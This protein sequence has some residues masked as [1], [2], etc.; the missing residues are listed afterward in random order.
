MFK[1]AVASDKAQPETK[2]TLETYLPRVVPDWKVEKAR[3]EQ[4]AN[5]DGFQPVA[6]YSA[7]M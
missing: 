7:P 1:K 5:Q 4:A 3:K 6:N 2:L